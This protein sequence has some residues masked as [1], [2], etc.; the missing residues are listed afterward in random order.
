MLDFQEI[1]I[2]DKVLFDSF[3]KNSNQQCSEMTFTNL[4]VWR[5]HYGFRH[6][7]IGK[8][9]LVAAT[10][11]ACPFAFFP[12]QNGNID[13]SELAY[14]INEYK[15]YCKQ[16]SSICIFD[17]LTED[18]VMLLEQMGIQ[19]QISNNE[20][21]SDY[22]YLTEHLKCLKGKAFDGKR[23]HIHRLEREH[24]VDYI[25]VQ[26]NR[27]AAASDVI[28]KW[29][30]EHSQ[31]T[32]HS[33][34]TSEEIA[35]ME[36]LNNY[37]LLECRGG[38]LLIDDI[39]SAVTFGEMLNKDTAVIHFEKAVHHMTGAYPTINQRFVQEEWGKTKWIN[40]EQ[41]L[42]LPGLRRSKQS[43]HPD[44]II[45]KYKVSF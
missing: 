8:T 21:D 44:K 24:K 7:L 29:F 28:K 41:D 38:L 40:R 39:P 42:G 2:K 4:F 5:K 20:K 1:T 12:L 45:K 15:Y 6:T 13:Y 31:E 14:V 32:G 16:K 18:S 43:Y 33:I 27:I 19:Y 35:C 23:N 10:D 17:R 26:S 11:V 22:V 25:P 36:M 37:D 34:Y 9:L 30:N 3:L